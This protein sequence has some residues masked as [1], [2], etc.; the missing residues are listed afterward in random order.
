LLSVRV[1]HKLNELMD[2]ENAAAVRATLA[3]EEMANESH[4]QPMRRISTGGIV[5]VLPGSQQNALPPVAASVSV[6]DQMPVREIESLD[7]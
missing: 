7:E 3:L 4:T 5:I 2:S 6:I 1:P